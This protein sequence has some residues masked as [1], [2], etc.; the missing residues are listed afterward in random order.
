VFGC[1]A[2]PRSNGR[3]VVG[4]EKWREIKPADNASVLSWP[5]YS[6]GEV[7]ASH[8]LSDNN[9]VRRPASRAAFGS[10]KGEIGHASLERPEGRSMDRVNNDRHARR[11]RRQT[12]NEP[13][14]SAVGVNNVR[15]ESAKEAA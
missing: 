10:S 3:I 15:V 5:T 7:L 8:G 14:L 9:E 2:E 13:S 11:L 12:P 1:E 6:R 4:G